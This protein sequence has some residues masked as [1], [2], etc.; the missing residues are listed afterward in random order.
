VIVHSSQLIA[1]SKGL[2]EFIGFIA[3]VKFASLF[4][5]EKFN[6]VKVA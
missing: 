5:Y 3:P 4:F 6:G 1:D 2:I